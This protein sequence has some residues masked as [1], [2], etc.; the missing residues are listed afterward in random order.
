MDAKDPHPKTPTVCEAC[1]HRREK[2]QSIGVSIY[3]I[4]L[5][6]CGLLMPI[7][8]PLGIVIQYISLLKCK[9]CREKYVGR[10]WKGFR[11]TTDQA[12]E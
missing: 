12:E 7:C 2:L 10:K 3:F 8:L 4:S 9:D 6:S 5:L 11:K 1:A